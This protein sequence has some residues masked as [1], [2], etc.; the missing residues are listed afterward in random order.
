MAIVIEVQDRIQD[1]IK[2][3]LDGFATSATAAYNSI[4]TLQKGINS[5]SSSS[6]SLS[7]TMGKNALASE[8]LAQAQNRTAISAER[9]KQEQ[10][11][12]QIA[13][14]NLANAQTRNSVSAENLETAELKVA[15]ANQKLI[16]ATNQAALSHL[17][18]S[19]AQEKTAESND[20][21]GN[22]ISDFA[23]RL[24]LAAAAYVSVR[25]IMDIG[26]A[27]V[28]LQNKLKITT[29]SEEQLVQVSD[30]I[31]KIA[32]KTRAP[33]LETATAFSRFDLAL[34]P[35]GKSQ[36][37]VLRMTETVNKA[38]TISGANTD[39]Q[40][41]GLLQLSQAFNKGKLDGDEF[42]T[43]MEL[44]PSVADAIAKELKV[45]R[46]ELLLLAPQGKIT[47]DIIAK[48]LAAAADTIDKKFAKTVPTIG[49]AL[50]VVKNKA[51]EF[52]G[53]IEAKSGVLSGIA[54][55]ISNL[56]DDSGKTSGDIANL[57]LT[58][59]DLGKEILSAFG[60]DQKS[61]VLFLRRTIQGL[62]YVVALTS[63]AFRGLKEIALLTFGEIT[64]QLG[65]SLKA[66]AN[67]AEF[68]N[69]FNP[70][71]DIFPKSA[72]D[73]A[74]EYSSI[75][76]TLSERSNVEADR[77]ATQEL[78]V[79][80]LTNAIEANENAVKKEIATDK[81]RG[82]G[83]N[84][85]KTPTDKNAEK[86]ALT[87]AK[88]NAELD[89]EL[90]ALT[91]LEPQRSTDNRMSEIEIQL[92]GKK[93]KLNADERSEIA[94]KITTI[95]E[96]KKLMQ[97]VDRIYGESIGAV[98][99]YVNTVSAANRLLNAGEISQDRYNRVML[100]AANALTAATDP[101]YEY[102]K[103]LTDEQS[104][105]NYVGQEQE[106][107]NKL[108]QVSNDLLSKGI[109]LTDSETLALTNRIQAGINLNLVNKEYSK[110]YDE[111]IGKGITFQAQLEAISLAVTNGLSGN[112]KSSALVTM[113][114]DMFDGTQEAFDK[115]VSDW[116]H[117]YDKIN[118]LRARDLISDSTA[119][120]LKLKADAAL[121]K[122][123]LDGASKMFG[124]LAS[125]QSSG[126]REAFEIGKAAA[127]AQ[128]TVDGIAA[129]VAALKGPPGPPWS[130][131]I[132]AS[133][134]VMTAMNISKIAATTFGGYK[135]G[136]FTGNGGTS[137]VA[138][139]VHGQEFVVNAEATSK[140]RGLLESMNSGKSVAAAGAVVSVSI[141]NYGTSKDFEV[142]QVSENE[143]RIIARDEARKTTPGLVAGEIA[144][145]NSQTSKALSNYTNAT[146]KRG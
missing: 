73:S 76:G 96:S 108:Q 113:F 78:A 65:I 16:T 88:L 81:L 82:T 89:K 51:T 100:I 90:K 144:N 97:E 72:I 20:S 47:A 105:L 116:Q 74:R 15:I 98:Q 77:L 133:T 52:F 85:T 127:I 55:A 62:S 41:A 30:Q 129:T 91:T 21:V 24:M 75:L 53:E 135:T 92:M 141:E 14:V 38:M 59:K 142:Q 56:G 50:T 103:R 101:L 1:S 40:T 107:Q 3:K 140:N 70:I 18:L 145:P 119:N 84:T 34:K 58:L 132:A 121:Y 29:E 71:S 11:K 4:L 7:A 48:G 128:A 80:K 49:Q 36:A 117:Y 44:M 5:L 124:N 122:E 28:E 143:I 109:V 120:Q 60:L 63:D 138:G 104:L 37:E 69:K 68:A 66:M 57:L 137:D 114:G 139:V 134:G 94:K 25:E 115:S 131:A 67:F 13:T 17:R 99:S 125:L 12:T 19:Q 26:N 123:R 86:R 112:D 27:Y 87:L 118:K 39:E 23:N 22:S 9:L 126:S 8:R 6:A 111:I 46:G 42:R 110:I 32:N 64:R 106:I 95:T 146:R 43:V 35:L 83:N 33:I 79:V 130:Y 93:I 102:N 54:T 136:G 2:T 10:I 45:T 31:F 61:A